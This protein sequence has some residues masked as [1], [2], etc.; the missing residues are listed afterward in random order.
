M[1]IGATDRMPYFSGSVTPPSRSVI[2]IW[3]ALPALPPPTPAVFFAKLMKGQPLELD[4]LDGFW[5][6][7]LK[8]AIEHGGTMLWNSWFPKKEM[9]RKL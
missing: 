2:R 1:V 4:Y 9:E 8:K 6:V 7:V 5:D 3:P